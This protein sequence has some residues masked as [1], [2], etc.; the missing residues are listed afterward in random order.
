MA[1]AEI[2]LSE[3]DIDADVDDVDDLND[4]FELKDIAV[5]WFV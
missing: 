5:L 1:G 3:P 2:T 4:E